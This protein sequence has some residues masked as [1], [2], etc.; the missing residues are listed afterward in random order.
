MK[1]ADSSSNIKEVFGAH[2]GATMDE[3]RSWFAKF[4]RNQFKIDRLDEAV[5][6]IREA[7]KAD[8]Q[9][10]IIGD[11]DVDGVS[12]VTILTMG[13]REAGAGDV[14][15]YIP[16]KFSEG[17]GANE[18]CVKEQPA[19]CLLILVDN[20]VAA[21]RAV[22]AAKEM[23][24]DVIVLDHH[25]PEI[26]DG[27]AVRPDADVLIDP[28][29]FPETADFSGYCGAGLSFRVVRELLGDGAVK[30][31]PLTAIATIA[32]VVPLRGENYVIARSG[33]QMIRAGKAGLVGLEALLEVLDLGKYVDEV[34]VGFKV[35][36]VINAPCR[37]YDAG[38][39][40]AVKCLTSE[41]RMEALAIANSMAADNEERKRLVKNAVEK[42]DRIIAEEGL[43]FDPIMLVIIPDICEGICGIIAGRIAEAFCRPAVVM[44]NSVMER[45]Q[46]KGS[47]RSFGTIDL[48]GNLRAS[49][50]VFTS[51]GGH[52]GACGLSM[53]EW[54]VLENREKILQ[55]FLGVSSEGETEPVY[56][57]EIE[58][59]K[60][61]EALREASLYAPYG[62]GNPPIRF[63]VRMHPEMA[64]GQVVRHMN[65]GGVKIQEGRLTAVGFGI[66]DDFPDIRAGEPIDLIG[67]LCVNRY[68]GRETDQLMI[69]DYAPVSA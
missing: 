64:Y 13:L 51:L 15:A 18:C 45:R 3:I 48:T 49:G 27:S 43:G 60:A 36:P 41:N 32:D 17:Y 47:G 44:T 69:T 62:E 56:D 54:D 16:H 1:K 2:I 30:Y 61:H 42:A 29:A 5:G 53:M 63:K 12:S 68:N 50:A 14:D 6:M 31:L 9:I 26:A 19:G 67:T 66:S 55:A 7:I 33:L 4:K 22:S 25:Q 24:M 10:R 38:A 28:A 11:H 58:P 20:G 23:G 39:D 65:A 52:P 57:L 34:D 59:E 37:I 46:L 21:H 40:K 35:A 8:R